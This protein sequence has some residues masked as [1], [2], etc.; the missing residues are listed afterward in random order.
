MKEKLTI[1][2]VDEITFNVWLK[3]ELVATFYGERAL[4]FATLFVEN[5]KHA[6]T[7]PF[8]RDTLLTPEQSQSL[9]AASQ[10]P[11]AKVKTRELPSRK[12]ATDGKN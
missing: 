7:P 2:Q 6:D 11:A 9:E 8:V 1:R 12:K 4:S 3:Y 5:Y 10:G